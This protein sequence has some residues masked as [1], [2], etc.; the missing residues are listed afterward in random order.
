MVCLPL[1]PLLR[2]ALRACDL[3]GDWERALQLFEQSRDNG[4]LPDVL[5]YANVMSA[6]ARN[7]RV[8]NVLKLLADLRVRHTLRRKSIHLKKNTLK[9]Y[10]L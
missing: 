4:V 5:M 9:K 10:K 6:C 2:H 3:L 8:G 1:T 7:G